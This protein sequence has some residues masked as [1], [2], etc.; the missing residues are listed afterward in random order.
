MSGTVSNFIY[1]SPK[2]GSGNLSSLQG[3]SSD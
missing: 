1:H 2:K 3:T